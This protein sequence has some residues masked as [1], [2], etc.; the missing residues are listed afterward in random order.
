MGT[1]SLR[2][3]ASGKDEERYS[4]PARFEEILSSTFALG[5]QHCSPSLTD[6]RSH[7]DDSITARRLVEDLRGDD[8]L[9]EAD[10][11]RRRHP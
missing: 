2:S 9:V 10:D 5:A 3:H 7:V 11:L 8:V 4:R 1:D 6:Q